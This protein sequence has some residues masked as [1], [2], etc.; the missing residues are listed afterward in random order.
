MKKLYFIVAASMIISGCFRPTGGGEQHETVVIETQHG[1][2]TIK[3]YNST[4]L[5]RDNFVKL[6]KEKFY[7]DLIF[8]RIISGFMIQGGD[9]DSRGA[10]ADQR[11]GSGGPGYQIDAEF[12]SFHFKGT[13]A[14][15][16]TG[17]PSNPRKRSS[18]SQYYIVQGKTQTDGQLDKIESSKGIKYTEEQ[19]ERYKKDGGTPFLDQEYTVFG[20]VI[21]GMDVID[22]IAAVK[23]AP[24]DRPL[25]DVKMKIRMK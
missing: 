13:L 19:R 14:A 8:H 1:D 23:T 17:G 9:P 22:K 4:P 16:R 11:L 15:A 7:D 10:T 21:S 18:G 5:H 25:E 24:G 12:G 2:M 3:L 6:V 20:E